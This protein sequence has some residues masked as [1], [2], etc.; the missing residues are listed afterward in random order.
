MLNEERRTSDRDL[1]GF[2]GWDAGVTK[3]AGCPEG[4]PPWGAPLVAP[5]A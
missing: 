3:G 4:H 1:R 2:Y 5:K